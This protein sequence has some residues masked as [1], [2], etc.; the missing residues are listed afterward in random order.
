MFSC[1]VQVHY[2][3]HLALIYH[4]SHTVVAMVFP[5]FRFHLCLLILPFSVSATNN[6]AWSYYEGTMYD[7]L[8]IMADYTQKTISSKYTFNFLSS[9]NISKYLTHHPFQNAG[10]NKVQPTSLTIFDFGFCL[11]LEVGGLIREC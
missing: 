2:H 6:I 4:G 8:K 11:N 1:I 9:E 3:T 7:E 10:S 5:I